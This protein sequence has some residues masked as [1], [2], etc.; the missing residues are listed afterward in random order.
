MTSLVPRKRHRQTD[1][2]FFFY[3]GSG[4]VWR[5][6]C[7]WSYPTSRDK[8]NQDL[9]MKHILVFICIVFRNIQLQENQ[10][11]L[12][13]ST[14]TGSD[15]V[16]A[17]L[18]ISWGHRAN[19]LVWHGEYCKASKALSPYSNQQRISMDSSD[20]LSMNS[21]RI[22]KQDCFIYRYKNRQHRLYKTN[23]T[24][25]NTQNPWPSPMPVGK[26]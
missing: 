25:Q 16:I 22:H 17:D 8:H 7:S 21:C 9:L 2:L 24:Q 5:L 13:A 23:Q 10:F 20:L 26:Q 6:S 19:L 14:E 12:Y 11:L 4:G 15:R 3:W 1:T 18:C